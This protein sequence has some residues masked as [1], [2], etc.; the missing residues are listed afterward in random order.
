MSLGAPRGADACP[1]I[2]HSL[3]CHRQGGDSEPFARRAIESLV[4]KLKERKDELDSLVAAVTSGGAQPGR[5]VTIQ[6]TLD[7][8]LQVRGDAPGGGVG[9]AGGVGGLREPRRQPG[10]PPCPRR[11]AAVLGLG[12][13]GGWVLGCPVT[14]ETPEPPPGWG[15]PCGAQ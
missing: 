9:G 6:R 15:G 12:G 11:P 14:F 5:C 2:V 3:L 8:R 10:K 7:G 4:K 13:L 1:S